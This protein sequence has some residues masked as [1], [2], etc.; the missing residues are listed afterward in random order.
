MKLQIVNDEVVWI[1]DANEE[2]F[3]APLEIFRPSE[4]QARWIMKQLQ[5]LFDNK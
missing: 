1:A 5:Q 2:E 3:T 4:K